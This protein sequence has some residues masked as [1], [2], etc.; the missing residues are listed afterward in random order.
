MY[1]SISGCWCMQVH[2]FCTTQACCAGGGFHSSRDDFRYWP[3]NLL[4][5]RLDNEQATEQLNIAR[6]SVLCSL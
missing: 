6:G 2:Y 3:A 1:G 5:R 4:D